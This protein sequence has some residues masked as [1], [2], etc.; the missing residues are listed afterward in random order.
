MGKPTDFI[1]LQAENPSL[2]IKVANYVAAVLGI[3][4]LLQLVN[5]VVGALSAM[6]L[7]VQLW[8]FF[9][10]ERPRKKMALER[11]MAQL[12]RELLALKREKGREL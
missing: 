6:W 3:G 5:V 4:T 10:Y 1:Q 7:L 9:K 11:E 8:S 12:E 2:A